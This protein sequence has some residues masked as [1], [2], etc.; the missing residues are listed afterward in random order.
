[1]PVSEKAPLAGVRVADF[2]W[3]W[4][5]PSATLQ[6]A[7]LGAEVI[8]IESVDRVDTTRRLPPYADNIVGPNRA[9]YFNQYSQGKKSVVLNLK[10]EK[11]LE[12]ARDI[13]RIAD[14]VADNFAAEVMDR[15]GL[16]YEDLKKIRPDI[17]AISMAGYGQTG[18]RRNYIAYGPVQ[19]PMIGLA[20]LSGYPGRGPSEVGL[21]YGDPNAGMHAAFAVLAALWHRRRTG[22]G[23]FIDLSQWEAAIGLVAEGLL[24]W[25][26][27]KNQPDRM[28]NRDLAEAPQGVFRCL[29]DDRWVA[30][31]C[32]SDAHWE[33]LARAMGR[34][35]LV[36][37]ADLRTREG[38]KAHELELEQAVA[39]WTA[40]RTPEDVVTTLQ[41]AGVPAYIPLSNR[42]VAEDPQ[43]NARGAFTE[44][45]HPEVGR[46]RHVGAPWVFSK[47]DVRARGRAPLLGEHT[48]ELLTS[49]LGY[50][51]SRIRELD[52]AG[53][54]GP[55]GWLSRHREGD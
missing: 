46:R 8:K 34:E 42:G 49:V 5:G 28:G 6:L 7:H 43:L 4:A 39:D 47:S 52:E 22:E 54:F 31:A 35:D 37:R 18:P 23:Q 27:N 2:T 20:A 13:V 44:F 45:D 11:G 17:I 15:L 9:G 3:V 40:A 29:G 55:P 21:S 26:F 51:A 30:I 36:G 10:N 50:D 1:M 41:A 14:V 12:V 16:G 32:W 33:A 48:A 53:A 19:V 25:V 24:D 38:R